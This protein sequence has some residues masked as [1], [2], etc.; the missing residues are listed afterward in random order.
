MGVILMENIKRDMMEA[1][2]DERS[3]FVSVAYK[4]MVS[5]SASAKIED[6]DC[7]GMCCTISA[8]N[9][10]IDLDDFE[11][12]TYDDVD[13]QYVFEKDDIVVKVAII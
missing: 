9:L 13:D 11:L 7:T 10:N 2:Y 5:I 4:E 12:I 1:M 3:I 6:V 8:E